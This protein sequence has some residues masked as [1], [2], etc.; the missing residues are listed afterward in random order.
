MS[1]VLLT[2]GLALWTALPAAGP[3]ALARIGGLIPF[4]AGLL[5]AMRWL[6]RTYTYTL[7]MHEDGSID[8]VITE[9]LGRRVHVVC[10]VDSAQLLSAV[11]LPHG[12]EGRAA[13]RGAYR[14]VN[15]PRPSA[16]WV[17]TVRAPDG[18]EGERILFT[19]DARFCTA[20]TALLPRNEAH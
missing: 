20:L 3:G 14:Y 13:A 5:L 1:A 12:R 7:E 19:P 6:A 2:L 8:F 4:A 9:R 18:G 11:P 17:L 15:A 16:A 10:R